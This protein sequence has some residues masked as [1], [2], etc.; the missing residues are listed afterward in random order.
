MTGNRLALSGIVNGAPVGTIIGLG[1][2]G[3]TN[4]DPKDNSERACGIRVDTAGNLILY[5]ANGNYVTLA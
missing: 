4:T 5:D 1:G 2:I 3:F